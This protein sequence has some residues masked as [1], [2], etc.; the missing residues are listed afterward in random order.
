MVIWYIFPRFGMLYQEKSGNP[1]GGGYEIMVDDCAACPQK[2]S[3]EFSRYIV[4]FANKK[5]H[6]HIDGLCSTAPR[7]SFL[8]PPP[9]SQ[10]LESSTLQLFLGKV[11]DSELRFTHSLC[12][13]S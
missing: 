12:P 6:Q 4:F 1:E 3:K 2:G 11:Q 7:G 9:L 10:V 8:M 5:Q 13:I